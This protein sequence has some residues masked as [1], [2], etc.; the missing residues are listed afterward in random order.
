MFSRRTLLSCASAAVLSALAVGGAAADQA[1]QPGNL[2][3]SRALY[4][5]NSNLIQ[6]GVTQLPPNCIGA[7]CFTA[8]ASSAYPFV[9][10]NV[11]TDSSFGITTKI[12]LDQITPQGAPINSIEVPNS[13]DKRVQANEDQ[14]VTSFSSKSEIALNLST[15]GRYLTFMGYR[16]PVGTIDASN[17]NTPGVVDPTDPVPNSFY[18]VVAKVDQSGKFDFTET[19]AYSG[20]NG[21]A[22]ILYRAGGNHDGDGHR[23]DGH[24]DEDHNGDDHNGGAE[25]VYTVGNAGNGSN[26]QPNGV[27]LGAGAQILTASPQPLAEQNPGLPTPVGS[28]SVTELGLKADKVGKDT[29]FRGLAVF[30]NVIYMTKGSGSNGV[31]T[32]YFVDTS[33]LNAN[34]MPAACPNGVGV[35]NPQATLPTAPIMYNAANLQTQG[36]TPYNMCILKGFNTTLAKTSTTA[37]PFGV[38]FANAKT[39]Y[40]SDEGNGTTTYDATTKAYTAA[41]AQTTAGLQKWV[42]DDATGSWQLAYTLT[43]GLKLGA[44][45]TVK[46]YPTGLNSATGLPWAP[47]TDGL[48]NITGRVNDGGR[49]VTIWAVTSTVSGNGDQ[50]ADPNKLVAIT[51]E[52]AAT[53]LPGK[54]SFTTVRTAGYGEA[55]RGVSFTPGSTVT[56]NR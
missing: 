51:D 25:L 54:E 13:S 5:L 6:P 15:D 44:P 10:N 37:F 49:S 53:T 8:T 55:L 33:G 20:N 23:S 29:N 43:A 35:P 16:A 19:N 21:R 45:Y 2:V 36:V 9:F 7:N 48:R 27:I 56:A 40:V 17:S 42:F 38:W 22:A 52:L 31:N 28:F 11:L 12:F 18:R 3:V 4:D 41:A 24:H 26:P 34:G 30:D 1:F 14:M 50:G 46:G 32:V 47:A 39:V